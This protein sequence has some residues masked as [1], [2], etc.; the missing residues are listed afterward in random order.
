MESGP[1]GPVPSVPPDGVVGALHEDVDLVMRRGVDGWFRHYDAT[2]TRPALTRR[3]PAGTVPSFVPNTNNWGF[4]L[5]VFSAFSSYV[6]N[7]CR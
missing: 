2:E 5:A 3:I 4:R 7:P 1:G 6:L